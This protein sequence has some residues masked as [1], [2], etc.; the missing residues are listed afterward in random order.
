MIEDPIWS[1]NENMIL[2]FDSKFDVHTSS[3]TYEENGHM[4]NVDLFIVL[5]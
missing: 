1:F 5:P 3:K 4:H 2:H